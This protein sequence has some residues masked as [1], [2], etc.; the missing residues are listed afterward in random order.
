MTDES[1]YPPR[2][3]KVA[4]DLDDVLD[5]LDIKT[6]GQFKAKEM[7]YNTE[8]RTYCHEPRCS[9]FV[10]PAFIRGTRA[11]CVKCGSRT[12]TLCKQEEH[13]GTPC[14]ADENKVL[15]QDLARQQGWQNCQRCKRMV[16]LTMGCYHMSTS[17]DQDACCDILANCRT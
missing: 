15:L 3:C 4:L 1:L 12:C 16:E 10:P 11:I 6:V 9:T 5:M 2:C 13:T 7:E 8:D 14:P 17:A